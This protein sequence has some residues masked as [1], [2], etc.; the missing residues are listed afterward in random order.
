MQRN[1][2]NSL[3]S[4][5]LLLGQVY[6]TGLAQIDGYFAEDDIPFGSFVQYGSA[7][8]SGNAFLVKKLASG[9][10]FIGVA[11]RDQGQPVG[12]T[13]ATANTANAM[14]TIATGFE[15]FPKGSAL[16]VMKFGRV[17]VMIP[18][19]GTESNQTTIANMAI[20][21]T[22]VVDPATGKI[23]FTATPAAESATAINI[24]TILTNPVAGQLVAVQINEL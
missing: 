10:K 7:S 16:S 12:A 11:V 17:A 24:G 20:G 21:A 15:V 13:L 18:P 2:D 19:V 8:T 1:Y 4:G 14:T 9:G 3:D 23:S 6:D 22:M 5:T